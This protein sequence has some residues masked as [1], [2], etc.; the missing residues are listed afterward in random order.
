MTIAEALVFYREK[1][2]ITR[3]ALARLCGV[4]S[5]TLLQYEQG[6][7]L[8]Q[9]PKLCALAQALGVPLEALAYGLTPQEHAAKKLVE[10]GACTRGPLAQAL[11]SEARAA[12]AEAAISDAARA[13]ML[14][15][16]Q[17]GAFTGSAGTRPRIVIS[18]KI[19]PVKT[20]AERAAFAEECN[21]G[22]ERLAAQGFEVK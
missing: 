20:E 9:I 5:N 3:A 10:L 18:S 7:R 11:E 2:G 15:M 12:R 4:A 8:P 21:Q 22:H 17:D 13:I 1:T 6:L 16:A 19:E 14:A